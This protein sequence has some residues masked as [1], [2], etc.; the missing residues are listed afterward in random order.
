MQRTLILLIAVLVIPILT[1][2]KFIPRVFAATEPIAYWK[3]DDGS[4]TTPDDSSGNGIDGSFLTPNPSWSTDVPSAITFDDPYSLDFTGSG[5]GVSIA[6]PS[7]RNF[8]ATD[9]RSFSFWYK[10][11]ADG[12]GGGTMA[13]IIS[14]SSDQFEIAGTDGSS[15][16]HRIAYYDGNWH[17]TDIT[18]T[19]GTWYFVTF[20]YDGT[21]AKFYIG[22]ELQ[23][24][25]AL[26]GRALSGTMMIGNR[27]QN[28][29]EGINGFIDDVRVYDYALNST[30]VTNL[31]N[32]TNSPDGDPSPTPTPSASTSSSTAWVYHPPSSTEPPAC[33]ALTP[34]A[35]PNLFQADTAGTYVNLY[36]TTVNGANGYNVQYG[37]KPEANEHGDL[38]GYSGGMWTIGRTI[39]SLSP[40]TSY[41]FKVQAVNGCT[42]G[43]W[44]KTM[45]VKTKGRT[46]NVSQ[47][48]ANLNP[49]KASMPTLITSKAKPG[50]QMVAGASKKSGSCSYT[51]QSGDSFWR[52]AASELGSG[53]MFKDL[54]SLN[55]GVLMLRVGQTISVCK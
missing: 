10:P 18:L 36:F 48:F 29:N 11:T 9:P 43:P 53:K 44:S 25:H 35:A 20:T 24:E 12:E 46:A 5:D 41:S 51:V 23:D 30:Q 14:W 13:R 45:T 19:L 3:F 49:F 8:A 16:T 42:S 6:W 7:G 40:N 27:V 15:S 22:D 31:S 39:S 37:V 52:I 2:G 33:N 21:T 47:M 34:I 38:F 4:G 54:M 28:P 50:G 1:I 55:P 26:A 17:S 32:G